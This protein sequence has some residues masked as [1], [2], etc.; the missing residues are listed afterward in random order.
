[1]FELSGEPLRTILPV[2]TEEFIEHIRVSFPKDSTEA[3]FV[4]KNML[5][6][7]GISSEIITLKNGNV[8]IGNKIQVE[9]KKYHTHSIVLTEG[10]VID[11]LH[12]E[13]IYDKREYFVALKQNNPHLQIDSSLSTGKTELIDLFR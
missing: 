11:I 3:A 4:V 5:T 10:K 2:F 12:S 1:M 8:F 7:C 9:N 13:I 6:A